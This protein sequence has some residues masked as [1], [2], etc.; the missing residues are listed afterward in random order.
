VFELFV[1]MCVCVWQ[2][3]SI[4]VWHAT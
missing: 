1:G 2:L 3:F 4:P